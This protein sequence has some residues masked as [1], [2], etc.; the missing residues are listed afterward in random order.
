MKE[1]KK[2][3]FGAGEERQTPENGGSR[4]DGGLA[5][6]LVERE[7]LCLAKKVFKTLFSLLSLYV[8]IFLGMI[9]LFVFLFFNF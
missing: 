7:I 5:A 1:D 2:I 4:P 3:I 6:C 9:Y 8:S